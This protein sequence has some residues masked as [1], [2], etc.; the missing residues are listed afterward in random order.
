MSTTPL[1]EVSHEILLLSGQSI[2]NCKL[3]CALCLFAQAR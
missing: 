1:Q 2:A 3:N